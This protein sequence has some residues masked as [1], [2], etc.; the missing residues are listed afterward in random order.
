[1]EDMRRSVWDGGGGGDGVQVRPRLEDL[2]PV[3]GEQGGVGSLGF[4]VLGLGRGNVF[5]SAGN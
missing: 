3:R 4:L 1:M 5:F 2:A